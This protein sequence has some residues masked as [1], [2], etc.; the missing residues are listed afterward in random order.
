MPCPPSLVRIT[1]LGLLAGVVAGCAAATPAP[2]SSHCE[3]LKGW[4]S[5]SAHVLS[6][7]LLTPLASLDGVALSVPICRV[8]GVAR[9]AADSD[10]RFEV[11]L[12]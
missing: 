1:A 12:P 5:G 10:I 3:A 2:A 4:A 9:P 6:A 7:E 11:W 8:Q